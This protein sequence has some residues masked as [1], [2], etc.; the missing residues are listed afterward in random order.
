MQWTK[1]SARIKPWDE[2]EEIWSDRRRRKRLRRIHTLQN[3]WK[4]TCQKIIII[5]II[6]III[7][8]QRCDSLA[9]GSDLSV[10]SIQTFLYCANLLSFLCSAATSSSSWHCLPISVSVL[11]QA[12]FRKIFHSVFFG[13]SG[14]ILSNYITIPMKYLKFYTIALTCS[15]R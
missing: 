4:S 5:I 6:I 10:L 3:S 1:R 13:Y 8:L 2:K 11:P 9:L 15:L 7:P 12:F 14:I